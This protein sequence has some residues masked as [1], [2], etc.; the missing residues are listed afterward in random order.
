MSDLL[1]SPAQSAYHDQPVANLRQYAMLFS[2][3]KDFRDCL[4]SRLSN[5]LLGGQATDPLSPAMADIRDN[6]DNNGFLVK[7]I[8]LEI[9]GHPSFVIQQQ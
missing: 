9:A 6:V 7:S 3:N 5:Q 8:L 4:A 2:R 1:I